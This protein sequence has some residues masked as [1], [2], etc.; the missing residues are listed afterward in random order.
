MNTVLDALAFG[1]PMV[2]VPLALE[3][4][5]TAARVVRAGA[6]LRLKTRSLNA[7]KLA[8]ALHRVLSEPQFRAGAARLQ[9]EIARAGGVALAA[10]I[11][12]EHL[13]PPI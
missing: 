2:A 4:A 13:R 6:G 11:I 8:A 10:N 7:S 12:E 5:A 3:Q 1:V 9:T